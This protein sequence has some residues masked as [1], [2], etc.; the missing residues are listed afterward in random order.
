MRL[1]LVPEH[2]AGPCPGH[3]KLVGEITA[4]G[5]GTAWYRFLAGAVSSSPEGTV[6]F[7]SAGTQTVTI[8]GSFRAAPRV[9]HASLIAIMEDEQGH[10]G[11]QNVSSGPVDYNIT[12]TVQ[13]P[14]SR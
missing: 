3:V 12:C 10:H 13:A 2:Y 8:E 1:H 5:P 6:T 9:P 7:T 11:P 14:R 4:D